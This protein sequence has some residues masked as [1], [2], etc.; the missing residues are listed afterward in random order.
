MPDFISS[1]KYMLHSTDLNPLRYSVW[2]A[3]QEL[4]YQGKFEPFTDIKDLLNVIT[5][6]WHDVDNQTARFIKAI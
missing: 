2:D 5:D 6:K 1:Q 3:L 4:V